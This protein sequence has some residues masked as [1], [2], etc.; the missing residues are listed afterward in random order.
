[1]PF[2]IRATLIAM[3][4]VAVGAAL[5]SCSSG[6]SQ[7]APDPG[8]AAVL[9]RSE[10]AL[11]DAPTAEP[12]PPEITPMPVPLARYGETGQL[13]ITASVEV[14]APVD[15][16]AVLIVIDA[17][18]AGHMSSY[19]YERRT[20]PRIDSLAGEGIRFTNWVSNSSWTRP[21]FTTMITGWPKRL[22]GVE[23][24]GA[25]IGRSHTTIAQ[26]YRKA[27][28]RTAAFM[29]N[30]LLKGSFGFEQGFEV[31]EDTADHGAFPRARVLVDKALQWLKR[32]GDR[33]FFLLVFFTDP[34]TPYRPPED[35]RGFLAEAGATS[36]IEYPLRE[37][38]AP[39]P[40]AERR[41]IVAAYDGEV[42]Y[43]DSQV[44]RLLDGLEALGLRGRTTIAVTADHG[45]IFGEH[46]CYLHSYHMCEPV[47]RVP[48][49]LASPSIPVRGAV[50][51][52]PYTHLDLL[53]TLTGLSGIEPPA[54]L[55]GRS[56]ARDLRDPG[57]N[58][59]RWI[60]SQYN[61][62]G[63]RRQAIRLGRWKLIH[64][65]AVD[66]GRFRRSMMR[67]KEITDVPRADPLKLP[68]V[69]FDAERFE[70]FDLVDDI[71][72]L[73]NLYPA[74][75]GEPFVADMKEQI[76]KR[77]SN[78]PKNQ[79]APELSPETLEALR[80]AGYIR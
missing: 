76:L 55:V 77:C 3:S 43:A 37:Y 13:R 66:P 29:G 27:G 20:T 57:S 78:P 23:L 34:H 28:F 6:S 36:N 42:A 50:E 72:E 1:M 60:F 22:H 45:E 38:E 54:G 75:Q 19:G 64:H 31:Y 12:I 79:P 56:Y 8:S 62:H 4:A 59:G 58:R 16:S 47:L 7:P 52:R 46:D 61:A 44:G 39:P 51:D 70:L 71:G 25:R 18:N 15:G 69:A 35:F 68:S 17:F 53:P 11:A 9:P 40:E 80:A 67:Q 30:P 74:K 24:G 48:F 14:G 49:V 33:P 2:A 26:I 63:V 10:P 32:V 5:G 21:S 41:A 65:N 73:K